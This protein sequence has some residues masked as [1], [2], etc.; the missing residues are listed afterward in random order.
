MKQKK[1]TALFLALLMMLS[2]LGSA[3]AVFAQG[4]DENKV[5]KQVAMREE[6][7]LELSD[8]RV[9]EPVKGP[10]EEKKNFTLTKKNGEIESPVGDYDSFFDAVTAMDINDKFSLYTVY[11]NRD[12]V[13]SETESTHYRSNNKIRL[14]SGEGGPF[15][16]TKKRGGP[17]IAI[18]E[19]A[20]LHVDNITLDG[21]NVGE[22]LFI[23]NNGKVTIG[24][25]AT[26]RN[27][28]DDPHFDGPAIYVT[29]GSL[30]ILEGATIKDCVSNTSGGVIQAYKGTTVNISGGTFKN[31]KSNTSD[32]GFLAAYGKL[33]ITGGTF[34][35]NEAK[36][37]GGAIIIG[38]NEAAKVENA[39]FKGNKASTGGAIYALSKT[40]IT[41]TTFDGN[42]AKWGGA[43][44]ASKGL[45]LEKGKFINNSA[46]S[47]GGALY[48]EGE[49]EIKD[50]NFN[51]NKSGS[52]GGAIFAKDGKV[53]LIKNNT[54]TKNTAKYGG[55]L[56]VSDMEGTIEENTF[57]ENFA[58]G[59]SSAFHVKNS[60]PAIKNNVYK[61][62]GKKD[63]KSTTYAT[64]MV[65]SVM[66]DK[67]LTIE[68][69]KFENNTASNSGGA[70][71][72][73]NGK[74][75][76][77]G[78][79]FTNNKVPEY[80]GAMYITDNGTVTIEESKFVGNSAKRGGAIVTEKFSQANP[81]EAG[82]YANLKIAGDVEFD[83]NVASDGYF[84]PP[85]NY[86]DFPD[87]KFKT[88][89]L[90]GQLRA[91][92]RDLKGYDKVDSV[93][94]NYDVYYANPLITV[95]YD[96]NGG[97]PAEKIFGED[98]TSEND[99]IKLAEHKVKTLE[100]T[101]LKKEGFEFKG[102]NTQAD[103]KGTEYKPGDKL[104]ISSN[105]TLYAIWEK[106][107]KP[108][109]KPSKP[110]AGTFFVKPALNKEDHAQYL[111][112]Y[113]NATFKPEN[114]MTREE[115]AVMFSRL[116]KNPPTK[117]EVYG[118]N[119]SD[120]EKNRWSATAI[121]YMS[122]VGI[123]KGYPDG[124]FK[125]TAPI[126][127]AEFAA[128]AAGFADLKEGE[129]T[130]T[131]LAP[132]HWAYDVVKKAAAAGWINGYPDGSFKAD[133]SITRA[134]V[135]SIT[136]RMLD[137]KADEAF[138]DSHLTELITFTDV[139]KSHWA[140]YPIAEATNGHEFVRDA[141]KIDEV[142]KSVTHR[143]F[144]YDK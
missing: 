42:K 44:Y 26:L 5:E 118:A 106:D 51:G 103:G 49:S 70:I 8:E 128:M 129:K 69:D 86:G 63:D 57:E 99:E 134:E 45:N 117:G 98:L 3:S 18:Q 52:N 35:N 38:K 92:H 144:A 97:T 87:L 31:N 21:G 72:V 135:V 17:Y 2:V 90:M 91:I 28:I 95:I 24:S 132:T 93:L 123:L 19:N 12:V 33:N 10:G 112:G 60:A 127:R 9:A 119:F 68:N 126:T 78:C 62:N 104:K 30:T 77:K 139:D 111:I 96:A 84:N 64:L 115:V 121:S 143:S 122:E 65:E 89:S 46:S 53:A 108:A 75:N 136:N 34:E 71:V 88:T 125:P 137:R 37:T 25:G 48:L 82:K 11:L 58:E 102:W 4:E 76:L 116:L 83:K 29:G 61:N 27:F 107:D 20:E 47:A 23:S 74:V 114:N 6:N 85:M 109:P 73:Q 133:N 40:N 36:K 94:N 15:K 79:E 13:M 81:A 22:C 32:G 59:F 54:F 66:S 50:S 55:A 101:G 142:W 56:F 16:L 130:F 1:F 41:G 131:D 80:G 120:V 7:A 67:E 140:Y 110:H 138:V 14:T 124:S 39:I 141:N 43:V 105:Q 113:E 100:E